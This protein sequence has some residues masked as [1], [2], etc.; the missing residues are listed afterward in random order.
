MTTLLLLGVLFIYL[1]T[2]TQE[3]SIPSQNSYNELLQQYQNK[4]SADQANYRQ[5]V[6]Y[7]THDE[8]VFNKKQ[9]D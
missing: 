8:I 4:Y 7:Q 9:L 6:F 1:S 2:N 3:S 5:F